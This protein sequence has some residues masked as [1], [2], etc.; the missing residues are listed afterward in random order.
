MTLNKQDLCA[1]MAEAAGT[2]S[3]SAADFGRYI[4][5]TQR[6]GE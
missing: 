5:T 4:Q 6:N 3:A 2:Y 1:A